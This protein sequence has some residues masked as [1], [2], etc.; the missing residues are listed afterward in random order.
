MNRSR[1]ARSVSTYDGG[2][3]GDAGD[4]GSGVSW[5]E[6]SMTASDGH[7]PPGKMYVWIQFAP[8]RCRS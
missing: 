5:V 8:R 3:V 6:R 2:D 7:S 1:Q 4:R